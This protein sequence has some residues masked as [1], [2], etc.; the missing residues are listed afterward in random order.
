LGRQEA[1]ATRRD[2]LHSSNRSAGFCP[3]GVAR[4]MPV[5]AQVSRSAAVA[6]AV[7]LA[8][9]RGPGRGPDA[10]GTG[11][12][13]PAGRGHDA[14]G[15]GAGRLRRA[16]GGGGAPAGRPGCD[17]GGRMSSRLEGRA[18]GWGRRRAVGIGTGGA[19]GPG[20]A[21]RRGADGECRGPP[22]ESDGCCC[23]R[24]LDPVARGNRVLGAGRAPCG[25]PT[26]F[27]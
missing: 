18:A 7:T 12:E 23:H 2:M 6:V 24:G 27:D 22:A 17:C 19:G 15:T 8:G 26:S 4:P 13:A 16:G 21:S 1:S 20:R 10:R 5:A 3:F 14:G 25:E 9:G 11:Q